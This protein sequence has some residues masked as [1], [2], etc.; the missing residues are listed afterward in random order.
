MDEIKT[1]ENIIDDK[2]GKAQ[3]DQEALLRERKE[4]VIKFLKTRYNWIT[5]AFLAIIVFIAVRIRTRN[6]PL[7]KDITTGTWTL[8]PDLDP[9]FFLRL[10]EYIIKNGSL[11][12]VDM[13]RYVPI[14]F[15]M[16]G[17]YVLHPYL[18]AWF[19]KIAIIF[20]SESVTQSA[21]IYPVFMFALTVIAFFLFTRKI[22]VDSLGELKANIIALISS[23]FLRSA[24]LSG[25]FGPL[26]KSEK[27]LPPLE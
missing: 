13:M 9:F 1:E 22:F 16:R 27:K 10:A 4:K 11:F 15:D 14:G 8:G 25:N 19:H 17:E 23:F 2:G 7:L 20:G 3:I 6:L 5:Y 21:V 18:M 12:A 26:I 24:I